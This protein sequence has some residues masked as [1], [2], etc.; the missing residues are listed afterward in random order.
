MN[1]FRV[2]CSLLAV[3]L[4]LE[5]CLPPV[6][7][8]LNNISIHKEDPE[9]RNIKDFQDRR[10]SDSLA[11]YLTAPRASLRLLAAQAFGSYRDS[12]SVTKLSNLLNDPVEAVR[13]AA[14]YSLGQIGS[15]NAEA[16]LT[17]AFVAVDSFGPYLRTNAMIL[18]ALGKCGTDSTLQLLCKLQSYKNSHPVLLEG[19]MAGFYRF[20]LRGK[21]CSSSIAMIVEI[22]CNKNYNEITRLYAIHFLQRFKIPEIKNYYKELRNASFEEKNASLRMGLITALSATATPEALSSLEE[23]YTRILDNRVQCNLIR[24][25]QN[26]PNGMASPLAIKALQNPSTQISALAA[27]YLKIH[28]TESD[29][30]ELMSVAYSDNIH[31]SSKSQIF[32]ALIRIISPFKKIQRQAVFDLIVRSVNHAASPFEKAAYVR[33]LDK[34]PAY[35]PYLL[36]L[37]MKEKEPVVI[38]TI[39]ETIHKIYQ[40]PYFTTIFK[41][42]LNPIYQMT[43]AYLS[44]QCSA[45]DQG[46]VAT[47]AEWFE[48]EQGLISRY[49]RPDSTLGLALSSLSLPRDIETYNAVEKTLSKLN[50]RKFVEKKPDYNHPIHWETLNNQRDTIH[51]EII[52]SKG[53]LEFELYPAIAPGTVINFMDLCSKKFFDGKYI[54]R[55]VPNFVIQTGCPRGDGYGSLDYSIRTETHPDFEYKTEGIIGMAS[56]GLDTECSQF[57][58]TFSPTPHLDGRYTAF[59]KLTKGLEVMG[60]FEQGDKINTINLL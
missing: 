13:Q 49:F 5:S 12:L 8:D 45:P 1:W 34:S 56:A 22:A 58:I 6:Q 15:A 43:T 50:K 18:E 2:L 48:K 21:I 39:T 19:L 55:L 26:F 47:I 17:K 23:L 29:A 52:T 57:F 28:A 37:G 16:P 31:W 46:S 30:Q 14:V 51:G 59:G 35:L 33:T 9:Y 36:Q 40:S 54:H 32:Q 24:G 10:Q 41:G 20:G 3:F 4:I 60:L 44:K 7:E 38:T 25:L 27:E 53:K 11:R 42:R